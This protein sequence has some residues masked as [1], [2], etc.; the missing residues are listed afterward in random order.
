MIAVRSGKTL[1]ASAVA[2][3]SLLAFSGTA[4]A[5]L[6][7]CADILSNPPLAG[8][9]A[10][11]TP[12]SV[13]TT[14]GGVAYCNVT[15]TYRDPALQGQGS[16]V[17]S[18]PELFPGYA[19]G[20]FPT[21]DTYE[22]IRMGFGF[23][24]NTNAGT[25]AWGGRMVQTAGGGAQGSV[26][27]YT[28]YVQQTPAAI[29]LS[30][31]SGH[32]TADSGSGD[33]WGVVQGVRPNY[34]KLKDWGGGRAYCTAIVLAKQMARTYYGATAYDP[35]T[36]YTYFEGFS[37]GGHMATTQVL[38]CP[39]EYDGFDISSPARDWQQFR[40]EDSWAAMVNKKAVQLGIPFTTAQLNSATAAAIAFCMTSPTSGFGGTV[41]D[42]QNILH[43]PR[44]CDWKATMHVCGAPT[45]P[46]SPNCLLPNTRQAELLQAIFDGPK[47]AAGKL[48]YFP[49]SHG[50]LNIGTSTATAGSTAQVMRYDHNDNNINSAN[51]YMDA[52]SIGLAGNPAGAISFEDELNLAAIT[53]SD[54]VDA[55]DYKLDRAKARGVKII[56]SHGTHDTAILF[57]KD[58]AYYHQVATYFGGGVLNI[59][60]LQTW[61][62]LYL[63]P[64]A[65]HTANTFL[66]N[67][68]DWVEKGIPPEKL[69]R[70]G[71][72]TGQAR[73]VCPYPQYAQ[74]TGPVGG[75]TTDPNNFT[76]VG[77]L[78][79]NIRAQCSVV[80]TVYKGE[81]GT[82]MNNA[83][84]G[85]PATLCSKLGLN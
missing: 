33:S 52:E 78:G 20:A 31:D 8:N 24:L 49:Y 76:C 35:M 16:L 54:Y 3:C 25:T 15:F 65:P 61:F 77:N 22:N 75:S 69:A 42:G 51:L 13:Q 50:F 70:T 56:L 62:R 58:P 84:V 34:G 82:I 74:Y 53:T 39:E 6:A 21:V 1:V 81:H 59:P 32:G 40:I 36:K 18:G 9:P 45:A 7:T 85:V 38:N 83:Q 41:I 27:S 37:G 64:G 14:T 67:L 72:I 57:R 44:A 68:Y 11:V 80:K 10:I 19:P 29:G 28:T 71:N 23:P 4:S 79:A 43:D 30:T 26:A 55:N 46:A 47:N 12:A 73:A 48:M 5:Q 66:P 60:A 2:A 17:G 63:M